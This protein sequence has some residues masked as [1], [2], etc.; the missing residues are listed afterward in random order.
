[1][2]TKSIFTILLLSI[3]TF[4]FSQ[5]NQFDAAGKKDGKWI[6]YLDKNWK[7]VDSAKAI[8]CRYTYFDH[9]IN[10]YPMGPC[11]GKNYKLEP[12]SSEDKKI[13]LLDGEFKWYDGKG[14][15]SSVHVFK[16]GEYISCK[17]FYSTRELNQHFDYTKKCEGQ[18][19]GWAVYIYDKK[20]NLKGTSFA[21]KDKKGKW[22]SMRG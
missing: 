16:N 18:L 13:K 12:T 14:R 15:L 22:P 1:M 5:I 19:H 11:G 3:N 7:K 21:C 4:I 6:I 9:G 8:F 2:K 17:E 20:G 10:I